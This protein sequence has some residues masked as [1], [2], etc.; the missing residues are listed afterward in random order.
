MLNTADLLL[1]SSLELQMYHSVRQQRHDIRAAYGNPSRQYVSFALMFL[2]QPR[3]FNSTAATNR[4][5]W[6]RYR[7]VVLA[8]DLHVTLHYVADFDVN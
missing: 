8:A 5:K 4:L 2:T 3:P 7:F 1:S 6:L